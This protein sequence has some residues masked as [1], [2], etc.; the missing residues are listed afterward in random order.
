MRVS[1][2][3][4]SAVISLLA[5]ILGTIAALAQAP[6]CN[7]LA[8]GPAVRDPQA[9]AVMESALAALCG[10]DAHAT[11]RT[12]VIRGNMQSAEGKAVSAFLWEDDLSGKM[13]EF[14]KE[15]G[16]GDSAQV[17]VSGHG[18]PAQQ[19]GG[20]PKR[21]P[22]QAALA[23][24]PLYLP[25]VVLARQLNN[26]SY[27]LRWVGT[28]NG[29]NHVR[30]CWGL[31][32]ATAAV[33]IQDWYFDPGASLPVRVEYVLPNTEQPGQ[34]K[35]ASL[36]FSDF[37]AVSGVALPFSLVARSASQQIHR[38]AVADAQINIPIDA[39]HFELPGR[40]RGQQ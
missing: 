2:I 24:P 38:F 3:C 36:E 18:A 4:D 7:A 34:T 15:T 40:Q 37:R 30:V 6:G 16:A 14:R 19:R 21:L 20:A 39:A 28:G 29:L 12:A 35:P 25:G 26:P 13:P 1:W 8:G 11:L 31:N 5:L 23:L 10:K 17:L 22:W 27:S 9:V 32:A 33:S